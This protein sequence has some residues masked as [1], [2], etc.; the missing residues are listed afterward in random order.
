M[1]RGIAWRALALGG[2]VAG[3]G[4]QALAQDT[5][6]PAQGALSASGSPANGV[7]AFPTSFFLE[8]GPTS[9]NDVVGRIPGFTYKAGDDVRG[10]GGAAGN[11][12]IDGERPSSK[13]VT[14]DD[15]LKRIPVA[16]I[17]RVELIRG[18]A[19]GIDMQ[20]QPVV[21]NIIRRRGVN[22]SLAFEHMAKVYSDH[23]MGA[24]PRLE[25]SRQIGAL[26]L[27]G[28][29][30][31]RLEKQQGDS[32]KGDFVRR[33]GA[34]QTIAAGPFHANVEQRTYV[35]SGTAEYGAL[36]L[37]L[38]AQRDEVPRTEVAQLV[39]SLGVR[40]TEQ[41]VNDL[42]TD[43]AEIGGDYRLALGR[44]M[45][46]R[47]IGLYTAKDSD[48]T[49]VSSGR[50]ALSVS[51]KTTN[52]HEAILRG[53]LRGLWRGVTLEAGG[54]AALNTLDVASSL[55]TGGVAVALPS[56]N[57]RVEEQRAEM[58]VNASARLSPRLSVNAGAR[59]ETSTIAQSGDVSQEKTLTFA[60]PRLIV[61]YELSPSSQARLRFERTVGQLNFE[62]FAASGDL[63]AGTQNVGNANLQP[64][65]A[66]ETEITWEQRFWDRGAIVLS[67]LHADVSQVADVIPIVTR[68]G[69]FDAPGNLG[70]GTRDEVGVSLNLPFDKVRLKGLSLRTTWAWRRTRVTDPTTGRRRAF[71][72][73]NPW[74]GTFSLTQDLPRLKSLV[75]LSTMPLGYKARLYRSAEIRVDSATPYVN[76]SWQYRP[77]PDLTLLLQ[78][79]NFLAR[80]RR[81]ERTLYAGPR[82]GG[83]VAATE[84]RS[85]AMSPFIMMRARKTF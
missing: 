14:L 53:T 22:Y 17:E 74:D 77:R 47:F 48:L 55:R 68:T 76:V 46:A 20:G 56:A 45:T 72:T 78:Y 42:N 1:V 60:K 44:G 85:A 49:S 62:D 27:Q 12:L 7:I 10:F 81:R 13:A 32:G 28:A 38:G 9:A 64:Q 80:D 82:S 31:A 54:E 26:K 29:V 41:T 52:G 18:G 51:T 84:Q 43:K 4:F 39:S 57:V 8:Y 34:G 59:F 33:N 2:L 15:A 37:N 24:A 70:D 65:Q 19:P 21:A 6:S 75:T 73:L 61:N 40:T 35:A 50:G 3:A 71:S 5:P 58:F 30:S 83:I 69:V 79:E 66:W 16:Q 11:V 67:A 25:G 23:P 36:R 63:S